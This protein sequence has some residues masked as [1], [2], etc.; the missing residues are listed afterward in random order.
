MLFKDLVMCFTVETVD[1]DIVVDRK[2]KAF[3]KYNAL[4]VKQEMVPGYSL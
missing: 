4:L 1:F 2:T 3:F